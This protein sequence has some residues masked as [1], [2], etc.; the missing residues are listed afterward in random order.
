MKSYLYVLICQTLLLLS[1]GCVD[2]PT[3]SGPAPP[4]PDD[5]ALLPGPLPFVGIW[6]AP[7]RG[8]QW[9]GAH[10]TYTPMLAAW[11]AA[12]ANGVLLN[13]PDVP[14]AHVQLAR[15]AGYQQRLLA[16][17]GLRDVFR[18]EQLLQDS[19]VNAA[20]SILYLDDGWFAWIYD[21][22]APLPWTPFDAAEC[23]RGLDSLLTI[24]ERYDKDLA[25]HLYGTQGIGVLAD[26]LRAYD[27]RHR[28]SRTGLRTTR[29]LERWWVFVAMYLG[30]GSPR[31]LTFGEAVKSYAFCEGLDLRRVIPW[32]APS[33]VTPQGSTPVSA[34]DCSPEWTFNEVLRLAGLGYGGIYVYFANGFDA[35]HRDML[36][37]AL[38]ACGN[39]QLPAH[40]RPK[41]WGDLR[42]FRADVAAV[43]AVLRDARAIGVMT[44]LPVWE[45]E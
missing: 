11:R 39:L 30:S 42:A 12:G 40:P 13:C 8:Y 33:C 44:H 29:R 9:D 43:E 21:S 14:Q 18:W 31:Y 28:D 45:W 20:C 2:R 23:W 6:P 19:A 38:W 7:T 22:W 36:L 10:E 24:A 37:L 16:G 34:P 41:T 5:A 32:I 1:C 25:L 26:T 27:E 3:D 17:P 35:A 4:E 15:A